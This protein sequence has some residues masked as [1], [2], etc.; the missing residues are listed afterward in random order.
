MDYEIEITDD[1]MALILALRN[2][3]EKKEQVMEILLG[4]HRRTA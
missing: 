4:E 3:P 2:Q 1:D